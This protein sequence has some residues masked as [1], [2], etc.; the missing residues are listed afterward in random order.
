MCLVSSLSVAQE[1]VTD[2]S[3]NSQAWFDFNGKEQFSEFKAATGFIGYRRINPHVWDRFVLSGTYDITNKKDFLINSFH[4]GG[5]IFYTKNKEEKNNFEFRL[6]Q[7]FKFYLPLVDFIPINN[8]VRL[9]ERFQKTFDG[10]RW[11]TSFRFRYRISTILQW[12]K[13]LLSFNK[14]MYIPMNVEFFFNL[15]NADR[16]N[17][18]VRISPG[19]GYKLSDNWR[20]EFYVSYHRSYNETSQQNA[21]D[22]VVFRLRVFNSKLLQKKK[23][24][25]KEEAEED[26]KELIE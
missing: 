3:T 6:A 4:L 19:I 7:G 26:V 21:S 18:V 25:K 13:H 1:M 22:E 11:E 17:D 8:Y 24:P 5:G 23:M 10:S 9:E 15:Q 14:G 2:V 16:H 20:V 12:K